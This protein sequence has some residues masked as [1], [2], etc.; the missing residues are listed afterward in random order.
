[1]KKIYTFALILFSMISCIIFSACGDKYSDLDMKF[2]SLNGDAISSINLVIDNA[3]QDKQSTTI[4]VKFL[5]IDESDI[6]KVEIYSS[7]RELITVSNARLENDTYY[8]DIDANMVSGKD[9]KLI[10]K[11]Y[12]SGKTAS[13]NLII[14]KKSNEISTNDNSYIISIPENENKEVLINSNGIVNL[15]P[16]G[17]TDN[18]YFKLKDNTNIQNLNFKYADIDSDDSLIEG[19]LVGSNVPIG[20]ELIMYPVTYME[21]Y[22][23]TEY[24]QNEIRFKFIKTLDNE[25]VYLFTDEYHQEYLNSGETIYLISKDLGVVTTP[26]NKQYNFNNIQLVLQYIQQEEYYNFDEGDINY[27]D[28]YEIEIIT[29][30]ENISTYNTGNN[31]VVQAVDYTQTDVNVTIRLVPKNCVGEISVIEKS[32]KVK[33]EV[34]PS[35][36]NVE[37]QGESINVDNSIDLYDYYIFGGSALG[38]LFNFSPIV[39]YSYSDLKRMVI[40]IQPEILNAYISSNGDFVGVNR[41]FTDDTFTTIVTSNDN[42]DYKYRDNKYVLEIYL[43]N[44]PL[45][46]YYDTETNLLLSEPFDNVDNLYIKYVE[47]DNVNDNYNLTINVST[48]Y[49]GDYKYLEEISNTNIDLVFNRL[50]G[51]KSLDVNAGYLS[52]EQEDGSYLETIYTDNNAEGY[53]VNNV[54]LNRLEGTDNSNI[55]AYI[56]YV[57]PGNVL[58]ERDKEL[59]SANFTISVEGGNGNPLMLKQY[60]I[61]DGNGKDSEDNLIIGSQTIDYSFNANNGVSN[62]ILFVFNKNTDVG[63]YKIAFKHANGFTLVI[64]CYLYQKLNAT[65]IGYDFEEN[66]KAFK[67]S[68]VNA[69]NITNYLYEDYTV[70]YIVAA[71]Q[72]LNLKVLLDDY[73]INSAYVIGYNFTAEFETTVE[74]VSD[75]MK[76][77]ILN[78]STNITF[79]KGT[80]FNDRNYYINLNI[81]VRVQNYSDIITP[82]GYIEIP[83]T[84][85]FFIYEEIANDDIKINLTS[86]DRYMLEYLGSYYL[87]QAH[88]NLEVSIIGEDKQYLWN[89]VQAHN[90]EEEYNIGVTSTE[91]V[92]ENTGETIID[93][94]YKVVWYTE[95]NDFITTDSQGDKNIEL[96]FSKGQDS[97]T[98]SYY[99]D[100]YAEVKQF[101]TT[102]TFRS[103]VTVHRPIITQSIRVNSEV[104]ITVDDRQDYYIDLKAGE[105]YTVET[106]NFSSEGNVT[107]DEIYMVIVDNQGNQNYNFIS[108]DY[109]T[110][111]LKVRDGEL[112][113]NIDLKLI[114]FAKDA[115]N[116]IIS[117]STAGF[118][119]ITSFLLNGDD[120]N[121]NLYKNAY[122]VINLYVSDGSASNPYII[123]DADDF[124]EINDNIDAHYKLMNNI[125]LSN[126]N[127]T[128]EKKISNFSGSIVTYQ[129][130]NGISYTYT[131][132]G[133][134]LDNNNLNLFTNF[135][136]S[137]SNINFSVNYQYNLLIGS[138]SY[139]G[140][141]DINTGSLNNVSVK[142]NGSANINKLSATAPFIYFGSLVGENR[143]EIIY[144]SNSIVGTVGTIDLTGDG[145]V[146]FG[147][148][149]GRNLSNIIGYDNSNNTI[150]NANYALNNYTNSKNSDVI[151]SVYIANEGAMADID[152]RSNLT[153]VD[154]A[155]G[156]VIGIN[157]YENDDELGKITIGIL[158]NSFA[159]GSIT[160]L[161]NVGGVIG[162]NRTPKI[163]MSV[164]IGNGQITGI[165]Q[166]ANTSGDNSNDIY[167]VSNVKSNVVISAQD[168][169]G[170]IVGSDDGGSYKNVHYQI[171]SS[172]GTAITANSKVGGI[173]GSSVNG[174]FVYCSVM[175]YRWDYNAL[176][177]NNNYI[178]AFNYE[179]DI[180]G[181]NFVAGVVGYATNDGNTQFDDGVNE[182]ETVIVQLSSVNAYILAN[183]GTALMSD[184][185]GLLCNGQSSNMSIVYNA[186]FMGKL[187]GD[188]FYEVNF[189]SSQKLPLANNTNVVFNNV[190][191]V[192]VD[193]ENL[194]LGNYADGYGQMLIG[195]DN[196][197]MESWV[198]S[199]NWAYNVEINGGYI[200][201]LN[202]N[203]ESLFEMSPTSLSAIIKDEFKLYYNDVELSNILHLD[204]Y[205]FNLDTTDENYTLL[206]NNLNEKYNTYDLKDLFEFEY[207][208]TSLSQIRIYAE[209]SNSSIIYVNNGEIIVRDVGQCYITFIS[210][211]NTSIRT[212]I[213]FDVSYATGNNLIISDNALSY[214]S[215]DGKDQNIAY[216]KAKQYYIMS[217]GSVEYNLI[218]YEYLANEDIYLRVEVGINSDAEIEYN[219]VDIPNYISISG[220]IGI[221]DE[222]NEKVIY[223]INPNT[224]FSISILNYLVDGH[225]DFTITPYTII[226]YT[227]STLG[228]IEID[229]ILT[230]EIKFNL[231]TRQGSSKILLNYDSISLYPND[232]TTISAFVTTDIELS[233]LDL[234][235]DIQYSFVFYD[236]TTNEILNDCNLS[237]NIELIRNDGLDELTGL[238]TIYYRLTINENAPASSNKPIG[239]RLTYT[240][241]NG[242]NASI[243]F[244][245]LPQRI[246]KIEIKNYVY[247]SDD[248]SSIS[249]SDVLRPIGEGLIILDIAPSNGYYDYLEITDETG[250]EEIIFAQI[251]GVNGS[252]LS[253]MDQPSS[254][255]KGIKLIKDYD[256]FNGSI[257]IATMISNT[258]SSMLHTIKVTAYLNNGEQ[259]GNSFYYNINVKMLPGIQVEYLKPNGETVYSYNDSSA[260]ISTIY[261][262]NNVDT[263]FRISTSNSD[264]NVDINLD[265]TYFEMIEEYNGYYS[266]RFKNSNSNLIGQTFDIAFT[267]RATLD[268]GDYEE[269]SLT[270][271]IQIV[272][273]VIHDISVTHSKTNSSGDTEIYGDYG[274]DIELEFYFAETDISYFYANSFWNK[275]YRYD[276]TINESSGALYY[277]NEILKDLNTDRS[278]NNGNK[279][280]FLNLF[281]YDVD[282][283][284][285]IKGISLD[286]NTLKVDS[287]NLGAIINLNFI[288]N[289]NDNNYWEINSLNDNVT[290]NISNQRN[291]DAKLNYNFKYFLNLTN[292]NSFEEPEVITSE[293]EFLNMQ[294]GENVNY[295]LA[296][297]LVFDNYSP[298]D[299][300]IKTFD[301]NGHTITIRSFD[302]FNDEIIYAGLFEQIYDGMIVMNL[303]VKYQTTNNGIGSY[304]FGQVSPSASSF[305]INYADICNNTDI[306][307]SRAYFGAIT[308]INNGIITNCNSSGYVALHASTIEAKTTSYN[309]EFYMGGLVAENSSTGYITNSTSSLSMFAL[310]NIGGLAYSNAG[311]IVSS[312]FDAENSIFDN[313]Y[314]YVGGGLIYAYNNSVVNTSLV[315]VAGFVVNNSGEIS[316]SSVKSNS[317][318]LYGGTIGNISAK[319]ISAGF[320]YSNTNLIYDCYVNL[321]KIGANNNRFSGFVN[322]NTGSIIRCYTYINEGN[323]N[324]S[325]VNM[326]A[327]FGTTGITDSYEIMIVPDGYNNRVDGLSTV[328]TSKMAI[329]SSYPAFTFGDNESAVWY[330]ES[331]LTPKLIVSNEKVEFNS[332]QANNDNM[333]YGLRNIE[334]IRET[335]IDDDGHATI[336]TKY[337]IINGSYGTKSNPYLIYDIDTW[338]YYFTNE[339]TSY[340]RLIC[341]I[342]FSS[343]NGN[344]LTSEYTFKGNIQGN[345]MDISGLMIYSG[346]TLNSIGLFKEMI[347]ADDVSIQNSVRNLD[348]NV[349]SILATKTMAVGSLAGIIENFNIYN[350]DID[351]EGIII[352]GSNAVGGL[353]GIVRGNFNIENISSNIGVNSTRASSGYSYSIYLSKNNGK[354]VSYNLSNVYYAGSVIGIL[355]GYQNSNYNINS[356]RDL[357]T[358]MYFD[359][360]DINISGNIT[361][362]GDSVGVAFGLIGERVRVKD[363]DVNINGGSISGAQYSALLAGENR[364]IILDS[365]INSQSDSL[366]NNSN[367]VS[368]GLVG[369]NLGGYVENVIVNTNIYN[370]STSHTVAGIIGRNVN[371]YINNSIYNGNLLGFITGGIIG[372]NYDKETI[373][374]RTSGAGAIEL[375]SQ[376]AVPENSLIYTNN[377]IE[378]SE[379]IY[380][381]SISVNSLYYWLDNM[382]NFYTYIN[383]QTS[384]NDAIRAS[385]VLGL[386]IGLSNNDNNVFKISLKESYLTFNGDNNDTLMGIIDSALLYTG[387]EEYDIPYSNIIQLD[388]ELFNCTYITYILGAKVSTFDAWNRESYSNSRLVFTSEFEKIN[389]LDFVVINGEDIT[390]LKNYYISSDNDK[391]IINDNKYVFNL[392]NHT[393]NNLIGSESFNLYYEFLL[394]Y[395]DENSDLKIEIISTNYS[396]D[397]SSYTESLSADD[398]ANKLSND[399]AYISFEKNQSIQIQFTGKVNGEDV[400]YMYIFNLII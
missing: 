39:D 318:N 90:Q 130:S 329:E 307:Y 101:N 104:N 358:A 259:I 13:I 128:G 305:N 353:A 176:R 388:D 62:A 334:I 376:I 302:L 275:V 105:E 385:R 182:L 148:L 72:T 47:T 228:N 154:S 102:F 107:N 142:F 45:K 299:V 336:I 326:F 140:I 224:P 179:P 349:K 229:R 285:V 169:V 119:D 314:S 2:Y 276:N 235:N 280:K 331:G 56:L 112:N 20:S 165:S 30:D 369:L 322:G 180:V 231:Y 320:V 342:D 22:E 239:F 398:I 251:D 188:F 71:G 16:S 1:M 95:N 395:F 51:V 348:I 172:T 218:Q 194:V 157:D 166:T 368:A 236:T 272:E 399:N 116:Q 313:D 201:L 373:I 135:A 383:N 323:R 149:V 82:D 355:D 61:N 249:Q 319:D 103:R 209:S 372:S 44:Q 120:E 168:M 88:A 220:A 192:V 339:S 296:K 19:F 133:I 187:E 379:K 33:G 328:E 134:I 91:H 64:N 378:I 309:I 213:L 170:G 46:F 3:N 29:S 87:D 73:F 303:N 390:N 352:V 346:S 35:D 99:K 203:G 11:H 6:G 189:D 132:Y 252:R 167:Y 60:S 327:P 37:M 215:I 370:T 143:G 317:T 81:I 74:L 332:N 394:K 269:A 243:D 238:Q 281:N 290:T 397:S 69:D 261:V 184:V 382:N 129:D 277:I 380:N 256:K 85:T 241:L 139:L 24:P 306:N 371:G 212:T 26:D 10:V 347:G 136:G 89:Y 80:Y 338:N 265:S 92:D 158:N 356:S 52:Q 366:F 206:Y 396:G 83:I 247:S 63:Q 351:G 270:L 186:Y 208:P 49:S 93:N 110:N 122:V 27:Y 38:A 264:G 308:P 7:P 244:T 109:K 55:H 137:M 113:T 230:N 273:F 43:Y 195:S 393:D 310:A 271:T 181:A 160:G 174:V 75:Y 31:I 150:I 279:N 254:D 32:F 260:N 221:T 173:A 335:L 262:A 392:I 28:F 268:N 23:I 227:D 282:D 211:L 144:T 164:N 217:T 381:V 59:S 14:G 36:I 375:N 18:V 131:L 267:T 94:Q 364:G 115:L 298:L 200:Y 8:V 151:F 197:N 234:N 284:G 248:G 387:N 48:I 86:V 233:T 343:I 57:G 199:V 17:S 171:L 363:V 274:V 96:I 263:R 9:G 391:T 5:N 357:S 345:N 42:A 361:T 360:E 321:S 77:D 300:N 214:N 53:V 205:E 121:P 216:N 225:F 15:K 153:H 25:N 359:V 159:T 162:V 145:Q 255:G 246:N 222:I 97:Y 118:D 344:P 108:I 152:I 41:I 207:A 340:Y 384:F 138:N 374:N 123:N 191:S 126:T 291:E 293:E 190:Y 183:T 232:N 175:S 389:R 84:K 400:M 292:S 177:S 295:I 258:Y 12:A 79:V 67:N 68:Y 377:G 210:V 286:G 253:V 367:S 127:Y 330:I 178:T 156:G 312:S 289:L 257:Y 324:S 146:Y 65:N 237:A 350:I 278:E 34:K 362:I 245:I 315:S 304:S 4:G 198:D 283:K 54:Y 98:T 250:R 341:D 202:E 114:I 100:I 240:L 58:G 111:T 294:S 288:L 76:L 78:N 155:I 354:D 325:E 193:N 365:I 66:D 301:G 147:G 141:F 297:D 106:E 204:Y 70:D 125:D 219:Y 311:K 266:L 117:Q 242:E 185:G 226:K 21:G 386:L 316:M 333:Y 287:G 161:N 40:S 50:E 223:T 124:W 163:T 196:D 337:N